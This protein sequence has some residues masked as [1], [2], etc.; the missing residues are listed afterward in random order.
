MT[1]N[2][3]GRVA[4][5]TGGNAGLGKATSI[6]Y[7]QAGAKVVVNGTNPVR[8]QETVAEIR[9][10]GGDAIFVRADVSRANEVETMIV[11][12]VDVY[13]RLDFAF[14]NAGIEGEGPIT[15]EHPEEVWDRT[16]A[17]NLK[18]V[19]L[20]MKYEIIQMLKQGGGS[21]INMASIGGLVGGASPAYNASK[22]GVIGLTKSATLIYADKGIRINA[23]CPAAMRTPMLDR[24]E[25]LDPPLVK[26]W[27]AMHVLGRFGEPSELADLVLWL[28]SEKSSFVMGSTI[29]IDG[30]WTVH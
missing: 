22:H 7:A 3:E 11:K 18:G 8:G 6:A 16:I 20:C 25:E 4:L 30:G 13:G 5:V 24:F 28:S 26:E 17:V 23:V 21:I 10:K 29:L 9:D 2:L 15:H 14:N 1:W 19:W 12:A 27:K